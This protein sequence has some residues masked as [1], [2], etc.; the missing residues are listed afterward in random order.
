MKIKYVV[1]WA[2]FNENSN[3]FL[4]GTLGVYDTWK[5]AREAIDNCIWDD[6]CREVECYDKGNLPEE[7]N[8]PEGEILKD[9]ITSDSGD[10]VEVDCFNGL[11]CVYQ[12]SEVKVNI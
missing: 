6:V 4:C 5:E 1:A 8:K 11:Q 7:L 10:A 2:E 3:H 9:W 12:I